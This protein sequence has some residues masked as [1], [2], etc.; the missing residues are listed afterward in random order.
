VLKK[1]HLVTALGNSEL[2]FEMLDF[3][4]GKKELPYSRETLKVRE[5]FS[6]M[7]ID[8][9]HLVCTRHDSVMKALEEVRKKIDGPEAEF[10]EVTLEPLE[11]SISDVDSLDA[12][13]KM[14]EAVDRLVA[15]LP[16]NR[17]IISSG[18]RKS[19][20]SRL[21]EAG[22]RYG[23]LGYFVLIGPDKISRKDYDKIAAVWTPSR[24]L[25]KENWERA[26]D[27]GRDEVGS[28][29]RSLYLLPKMIQEPLKEEKI[30]L[31]P[32]EEE[33]DLEWLK[34]LPKAD[35]HCHLGGAQDAP[36]LKKL[37]SKLLEDLEISQDVRSSIKKE[38]EKRLGKELH[39]LT[40]DDLRNLSGENGGKPVVHCLQNLKILFEMVDEPEY[41]CNAVLVDALSQTQ[42]LQLSR[43]GR[44]IDDDRVDWPERNEDSL[45]WYMSCGDLGGSALLQTANTL[46]LALKTLMQNA[47]DENVRYMEVRCS[48][49]NYTRAGKLAITDALDV[50]IEEGAEFMSQHPGFQVNFLVMATRHKDRALLASHV[51]AA[52]TYRNPPK[53]LENRHKKVPRVVGFDLAGQEKHYD[54]VEF[55]EE[56][57]PLHRHFMNITIH[58]GEMASSDKIWQAIYLLHAKRIGHGLKLIQNHKMMDFVRDHGLAIE[59]CP[60]SNMQTNSFPLFPQKEDENGVYPLH[61]YLAHGINVTVNTDNRFISDT[62]MT[63]EYLRAGQLTPQ[64]LSK[65]AVLKLIKNSFQAAFLPKDEKDRLLKEID[66]EIFELMLEE[67]GKD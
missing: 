42:I 49:E 8:T 25:I 51:A 16:G 43:D 4:N 21:I 46:S 20:T 33:K 53:R 22:M 63:Q 65:W 64:G 19:M 47:F 45:T 9:L 58:A 32:E 29:F 60:S 5:Q 54:P 1:L 62:T 41:I 15:E 67:F 27:L 24:Q 10:P 34:R 50:L 66:Q 18:G 61:K 36:L 7:R 14:K 55:Q 3:F 39:R 59:M 23:C 35:L 37:A 17:T 56:F 30:G 26:R 28:S 52:V 13:R 11:L 48:P 38:F 40:P 12:D 6:Q 2:I 31:S 44:L 57:M